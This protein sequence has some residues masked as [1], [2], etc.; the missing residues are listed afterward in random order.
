[1]YPVHSEFHILKAFYLY[2]FPTVYP[3]D[4]TSSARSIL[5]YKEFLWKIYS[6]TFISIDFWEAFTLPC[7]PFITQP[8]GI[9]TAFLIRPLG[10]VPLPC[11]WIGISYM[12]RLE[13][14]PNTCTMQF[15]VSP[16]AQQITKTH[17]VSL[18]Q[19]YETHE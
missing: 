4:Q 14:P 15:S 9:H 6:Y 10:R 8:L 5:K 11:S 18:L 7:P 17:T 16:I 1:M 12:H 19:Y 3:F 13:S 2:L